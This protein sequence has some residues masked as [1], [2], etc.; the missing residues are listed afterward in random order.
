[1]EQR[2]LWKKLLPLDGL[3]E[4]L[5]SRK[6]LL[7]TAGKSL[8]QDGRPLLVEPSRLRVL[9]KLMEEFFR[10][11]LFQLLSEAKAAEQSARTVAMKL[12]TDN[13]EALAKD[14]R[15]EFNKLRQATITGEILE[16]TAAGT[17]G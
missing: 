9:E 8:P 7:P 4:N 10:R 16:I 14:L 2:V 13:A 1:L 3:A 11:A 17:G 5:R 12:A 6:A 15:L